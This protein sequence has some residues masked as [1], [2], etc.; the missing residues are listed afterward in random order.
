MKNQIWSI[1]YNQGFYLDH[2]QKMF[3]CT[4]TDSFPQIKPEHILYY[5]EIEILNS[6]K[7]HFND[8]MFHDVNITLWNDLET[9]KPLNQNGWE[10][11]FL[12]F[13]KGLGTDK[14]IYA[15]IDPLGQE[16]IL[17]RLTDTRNFNT[18]CQVIAMII[19]QFEKAS[20]LKSL[21]HHLGI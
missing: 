5:I 12:S 14:L 9:L 4:V 17:N 15:F 7:S 1:H 20:S 21:N 16:L 19:L 2:Y 3:H 8:T 11:K 10:L 18:F 6:H 13:P